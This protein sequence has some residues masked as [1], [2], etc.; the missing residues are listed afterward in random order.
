[1]VLILVSGVIV[2][3]VLSIAII[4]GERDRFILRVSAMQAGYRLAHLAKLL[5]S[6][7]PLEKQEIITAQQDPMLS[8]VLA[9]SPSEELSAER[10]DENQTAS[11][12]ETLHRYLGPARPLRVLAIG[13]NPET[14][15][16]ADKV[17]A[18]LSE[19]APD[20]IYAAQI[21]LRDGF[22]LSFQH[23]IDRAIFD[24]PFYHIALGMLFRLG[25]VIGVA[26]IAVRLAVQPLSV[27]ASAAEQLGK[28]MHRKPL[29]ITGP[30]EV[31]RAAE[32]FNRM[33]ARLVRFIQDRTRLLAAIS[34]D[35]KTP[36]TRLRLRVELLENEC[37][38]KK[39]FVND[40]EEMEGL[41]NSTLEFIRGAEWH[42]SAQPMDVM[43][44]LE[45]L[46]AD[47]QDVGREVT[48]EGSTQLPLVGHPQALKRCIANLV[49]N[50]VLYGQRARIVVD[51]DH[52]H[53]RLRI[54][55]TGP[56][57][58]PDELERVFAP[59][60]RLESSRNRASGGTGLGLSI[61]RNIARGH[62]GELS[63]HNLAAGGLEAILV[64]PRSEVSGQAQ[65]PPL[66]GAPTI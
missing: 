54:R 30:M 12:T 58:P 31:R 52:T 11:F 36:I 35:L 8:L 66:L 49:D 33:Q 26:L 44:L 32:T 15:L 13:P 37:D 3:Q 25:I 61:A 14:K 56:G 10:S 55:D 2:A 60:F 22:W 4:L 29:A 23:R 62:G 65:P 43:A 38:L 1:M 57:I 18:I 41:V 7:D 5:D 21:G 51:G 9:R 6:A 34:H 28:D 27:L 39:R 24:P 19:Q 64:L 63:L 50:A 16:H 42:E 45:S 20:L 47:A 40:L 48:I 53:L 46:Q 59:F 17:S